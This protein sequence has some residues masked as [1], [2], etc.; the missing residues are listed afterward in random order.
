VTDY[1]PNDPDCPKCSGCGCDFTGSGPLGVGWND[2]HCQHPKLAAAPTVGIFARALE[3]VDK[4]LSKR[5]DPPQPITFR[6]D[7]GREWSLRAE[8]S[9]HE[10]GGCLIRDVTPDDLASAKYVH[11]DAYNWLLH[12][13]GF[14]ASAKEL[15]ALRALEELVRAKFSLTAWAIGGDLGDLLKAI[16]EAREKKA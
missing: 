13:A 2:C 15:E 4:L 14:V 11:V 9:E 3:H 1:I 8:Q 16:D 6:D 10:P 7:E 12:R 5:V